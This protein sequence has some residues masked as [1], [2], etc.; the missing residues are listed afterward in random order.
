[1]VVIFTLFALVLVVTA[2]FNKMKGQPTYIFGYSVLWVETGS[3]ETTIPARSYIATQKYQDQD[4]KVGDVITFKCTDSTSKVYGNYVTHRI[5]EKTE[6]GYK[7]KGDANPSADKWT[8]KDQDITSVYVKNLDFFTVLGRIF[9]SWV[10]LVAIGAVFI[11]STVFIY[12]PEI[13]KGLK[14]EEKKSPEDAKQEE[15]ERRIQEEIKRL[16][17]ENK[18][19]NDLKGN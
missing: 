15:I 12:V 3:M 8:V 18:K 9:G 11:F 6:D 5:I 14:D 2:L 13:V 16:E 4:L 7:T 10:G 19:N 17:E 1:M